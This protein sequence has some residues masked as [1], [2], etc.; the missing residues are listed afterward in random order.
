[1]KRPL[2]II[3]MFLLLGAV[4]NV[5]VAWGCAVRPKRVMVEPVHIR[6]KSAFIRPSDEAK[7]WWVAHAPASFL[8]EPFAAAPTYS[9][10]GANSMTMW[11]PDP[12]NQKPGF[13]DA[14]SRRR[15]GWPLRSMEGAVWFGEAS[16][17]VVYDAAVPLGAPATGLTPPSWLPLRPHWPGFAVN[18][19]F[20]ATIL[21]LLVPGPFALRR[22]LRVRRGLCPACAYQMGE[23][24]VCTECGKPLPSST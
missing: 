2:L 14:V 13:G 8:V 4:V 16:F 12:D 18:T 24:G 21:W 10:F 19:I 6:P 1:M 5:A 17:Q 20:Y 15:T 22:F 7:E 9:W 3:G 11:S 23:S